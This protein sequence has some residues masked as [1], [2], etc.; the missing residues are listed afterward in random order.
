MCTAVHTDIARKG[1]D[2]GIHEILNKCPV[3]NCTEYNSSLHEKLHTVIPPTTCNFITI[4]IHISTK[5]LV[6]ASTFF[7]NLY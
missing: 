2:P 6:F 3:P 4:K 5:Y 7:C 1:R